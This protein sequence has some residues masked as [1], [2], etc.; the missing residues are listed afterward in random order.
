MVVPD[1][2]SRCHPNPPYGTM[3][4]SPAEEDPNFP[5]V[6]DKNSATITLPKRQ[7][8]ASLIQDVHDSSEPEDNPLTG[9]AI[10]QF[11][12]LD[13]SLYDADTEEDNYITP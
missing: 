3:D 4:S 6:S 2:L 1:A 5:Y 8:L 9:K 7:T 13:Y 12:D 10:V 11:I